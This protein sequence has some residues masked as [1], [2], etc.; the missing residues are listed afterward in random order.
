MVITDNEW[1][2]IQKYLPAD[3]L[4]RFNENIVSRSFKGKKIKVTIKLENGTEKVVDGQKLNEFYAITPAIDKFNSPH[5]R[6]RNITH[7][8]FGAALIRF[9]SKGKCIKFWNKIK[10]LNLDI[11]TENIS[12]APDFEK[13][14]NIV[15]KEKE[16]I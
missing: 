9:R 1:K 2:T 11:N 14:R 12:E 7:I 5:T 13:L 10:D 8:G 4:D 15:M 3:I 6:Y 16:K